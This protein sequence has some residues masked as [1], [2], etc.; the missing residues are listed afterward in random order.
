MRKIP[1]SWSKTC[2]A[3]PGL[4]VPF[5]GLSSHP[6]KTS[7]QCLYPFLSSASLPSGKA[8]LLRGMEHLRPH[9]NLAALLRGCYDYGHPHFTT[10]ATEAW[11]GGAICPS[12]H[13]WSMTDP[14]CKSR[15]VMFQS[16]CPLLFS[17]LQDS[18]CQLTRDPHSFP[19]F[20]N[21]LPRLRSYYRSP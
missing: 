8:L 20:P 7:Q 10:K 15:C 6:C 5:H 21:P 16:H 11:K 19:A 18:P 13:S 3:C 9:I 1:W 12:S 4:P 14:A 2:E 17:L